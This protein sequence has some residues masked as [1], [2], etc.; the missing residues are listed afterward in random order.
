MIM[1][2]LVIFVVK[3]LLY[4]PLVYVEVVLLLVLNVIQ[5]ILL[6]VLLVPMA[7]TLTLTV[8]VRNVLTNV[9]HV[10]MQQLVLYVLM[11]ILFVQ[12]NT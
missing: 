6:N 12:T 8:N 10:L 1:S 7:F 4:H 3:V 2:T 11:A 9:F 5:I